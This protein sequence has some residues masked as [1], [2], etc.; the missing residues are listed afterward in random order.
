MLH[1]IIL[2]WYRMIVCKHFNPTFYRT[3]I[4]HKRYKY[5]LHSNNFA[6]IGLISPPHDSAS[7]KPCGEWTLEQEYCM[8]AL[9][10][11]SSP[12]TN[13]ELDVDAISHQASSKL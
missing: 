1:C 4:R 6:F 13:S 2:T 3:I 9:C 12:M 5:A 7:E 11:Q 8:Q 10:L